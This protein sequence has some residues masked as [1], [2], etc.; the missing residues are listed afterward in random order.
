MLRILQGSHQGHIQKLVKHSRR[1]ISAKQSNRRKLLNIASVSSITEVQLES[2]KPL[3][4][5][6]EK[7]LNL[8]II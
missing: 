5:N 2:D 7:Y 4:T 1:R 3:R 6:T 8:T